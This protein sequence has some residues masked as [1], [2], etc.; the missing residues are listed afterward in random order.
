MSVPI[1]VRQYR[2]LDGEDAIARSNRLDYL[3]RKAS[4]LECEAPE[5]IEKVALPRMRAGSH[6]GAKLRHCEA[7]HNTDTIKKRY[8]GQEVP[9]N[10]D[11]HRQQDRRR[12]SI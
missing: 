5:A 4:G 9:R 8:N 3:I 10:A 11:S 6:W 1:S 7:R 12:R 2:A